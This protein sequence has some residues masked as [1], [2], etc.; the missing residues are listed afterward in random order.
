MREHPV[1]DAVIKKG[2]L[3]LVNFRLHRV[4][5][6]PDGTTVYIE[7]ICSVG[8]LTEIDY[9]Y[10]K[11]KID[12]CPY[13]EWYHRKYVCYLPG[14]QVKLEYT[15]LLARAV[16]VP[17]VFRDNAQEIYDSER[18]HNAPPKNH[19]NFLIICSDLPNLSGNYQGYRIDEN[20]IV[21]EIYCN[22]AQQRI[23]RLDRDNVLDN[24]DMLLSRFH[25]MSRILDMHHKNCMVCDRVSP[26]N[27]GST[28]NDRDDYVCNLCAECTGIQCGYCNKVEALHVFTHSFASTMNGV[29]SIYCNPCLREHFFH[30]EN[31]NTWKVRTGTDYSESM[32]ID[33]ERKCGKCSEQIIKNISERPT[34]V[35]GRRF[36]KT[37]KS[38]KLIKYRE[39]AGIELEL[40]RDNGEYYENDGDLRELPSGWY[41]GSDASIS[42]EEYGV[43]L[44]TSAPVNGDELYFNITDIIRYVED[45]QMWHDSSCGMHCHID[46]RAL[47]YI[48]LKRILIIMLRMERFLY[49]SIPISRMQ[50]R[51]SK[52]LPRTPL[53]FMIEKIKAISSMKEFAKL[54][55]EDISSSHMT[56]DK[57]NESR[58]R[59]LNLHSR[60]FFGSVEFRYFPMQLKTSFVLNWLKFCLSVVHKSKRVLTKDFEDTNIILGL[61]D[62]LDMLGEKELY[63]FFLDQR[64]YYRMNNNEEVQRYFNE[65]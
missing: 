59:G 7:N 11:I 61:E 15:D 36:F 57:Y 54:W 3:F 48:Q 40:I 60:F 65:R 34:R 22:I 64:D 52:P 25:A 14:K 10:F 56:T 62:Y 26:Q 47:G 9:P 17:I 38:N 41:W 35:V 63:Q 27:F 55:Y 8:R 6:S 37:S 39:Y 32:R 46:A 12:D 49:Q 30:C 2:D 51:Y 31:C 45:K 1:V 24:L 16:Q 20:T 5:D 4:E 43:E 44:R 28:M 18:G 42:S 33:E 50:Q 58:Y 29:N 19:S 13:S 53:K 21:N 23:A